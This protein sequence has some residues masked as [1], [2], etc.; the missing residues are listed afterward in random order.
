MRYHIQRF[1]Q[2][3]IR[4]FYISMDNAMTMQVNETVDHLFDK[5]LS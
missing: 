5:T 2:Q 1:G 3:E 4:K